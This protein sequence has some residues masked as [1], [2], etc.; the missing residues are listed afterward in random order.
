LSS[1]ARAKPNIRMTAVTVGTT[2]RRN[3]N[4]MMVS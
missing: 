3:L 1:V 4:D 2:E